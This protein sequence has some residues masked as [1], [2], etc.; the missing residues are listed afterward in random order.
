MMVKNKS[1]SATCSVDELYEYL[2]IK[3]SANNMIFCFLIDLRRNLLAN[4][5]SIFATFRSTT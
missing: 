2:A 3:I 4:F 5:V 1:S